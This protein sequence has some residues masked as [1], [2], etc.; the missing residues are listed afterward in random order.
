MESDDGRMETSS[1]LWLAKGLV[2]LAMAIVRTLHP[3]PSVSGH[4]D[5]IPFFSSSS[6]SG[7]ECE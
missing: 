6:L 7:I 4:R 5:P 1:S 2:E 3:S